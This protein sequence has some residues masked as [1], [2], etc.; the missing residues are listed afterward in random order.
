MVSSLRS[1]VRRLPPRGFFRSSLT[2]KIDSSYKASAGAASASIENIS[3]GVRI[4]AMTNT[5]TIA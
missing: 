2:E 5:S 1:L 4:A 3:G